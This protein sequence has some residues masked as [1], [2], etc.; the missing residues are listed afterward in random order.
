MHPE[1]HQLIAL[2][3]DEPVDVLVI[4]HV[5][6]CSRCTARVAELG[7]VQDALR[8]LPH[9]PAP[10]GAW[11]RII[12]RRA[13]EEAPVHSRPR[14]RR[15]MAISLVASVVV[16]SFIAII[17]MPG[18]RHDSP[19]PDVAVT[20]TVELQQRSR[21]L[22]YLLERYRAPVAVSLRTANAI[23]ELEDSIALIDYRLNAARDER[24]QRELWQRR[25][26]LM[27]T[28]VTVRAAESYLDSI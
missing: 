14:A 10:D 16:A 22:E 20:D 3:D 27:E 9:L 11:E 17:A 19:A 6:D 1:I 28:L 4:A 2:R 21:E 24:Q 18:A 12:A 15:A 23:S 7:L 25:I 13:A 8:D 5:R 26:E